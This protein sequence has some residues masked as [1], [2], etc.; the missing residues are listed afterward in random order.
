VRLGYAANRLGGRKSRASRTGGLKRCGSGATEMKAAGYSGTPLV[1][2]IGIKPNQKLLF[3]N[4]PPTF[5]KDL[6]KLPEGA[7]QSNGKAPLDVAVFFTKSRAELEK[8]FSP[9]A[10]RVA[11]NGMLWVGWPKKAS[12]VE[13]D[14]NENLVREIGLAR[15]MVDV[16]VCAIDETW[17]GLKFVYRVKDRP[18]AKR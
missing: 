1:S 3:R 2:K 12:G 15:G 8:E 10:A 5:A 9:L 6:G 14:L 7:V 16:K 4:S 18:E 11:S 17:S 13:T